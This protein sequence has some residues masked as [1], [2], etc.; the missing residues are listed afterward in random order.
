[1]ICISWKIVPLQRIYLFLLYKD[2]YVNREKL[3]INNE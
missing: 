2:R 1:M 3:L